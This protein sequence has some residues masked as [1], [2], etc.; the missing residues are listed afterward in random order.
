MTLRSLPIVFIGPSLP[1]DAAM[2]LLEADYRPP[3][4]LG[5]VWRALQ[6]S[7]PA[8]G[9]IDGFFDCVPAVWHK[10]ILMA[11]AESVPVFG[12]ASMGALRAAELAP[13]GMVGV[14][15][16]FEAFRSGE[17]EDDD[18]VA[19]AHG[20]AQQGYRPLSEP[21]VNIRAT[22]ARAEAVGV[23]NG[24]SHQALLRAAKARF[25]PERSWSELL[26]LSSVPA[27]QR[28][29]LRAW[30]PAARVDQKRRDAEAMLL[31]MREALAT[32]GEVAAPTFRFEET[33]LFQELVRQ[34]GEASAE[35]ASVLDELALDAELLRSISRSTAALAGD[36]TA[37]LADLR[38]AGQYGAL[39]ARH[40]AK[41]AQAEMPGTNLPEPDALL[42]WFFEDRLG[43]WPD[44]VPAFLHGN[45]WTDEERLLALAT[46]EYLWVRRPARGT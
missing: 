24:A 33:S 10:E 45:G 21:M 22:L 25:Y 6:C 23:L 20:D 29:A 11:L 36:R 31:Q 17:L 41:A 4:E 1:R 34:E 5:D 3:V 2:A 30:L 8:I 26:R 35:G 43:G 27:E 39:L 16:I 13:F 32:P 12:A 38:R 42:A 14:G 9:I 15:A 7:P 44:N 19:L 28:E 37:L 18:E 46:R 40:R